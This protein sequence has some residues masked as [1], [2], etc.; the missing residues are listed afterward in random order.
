MITDFN[1]IIIGAGASGLLAACNLNGV[2]T[3]LIEKNTCAG[4]KMLISGAGQCNFTH[5]GELDDFLKKYGANS[6]FLKPALYNFNNNDSIK[7]FEKLGVESVIRDDGKVFP[8]SLK[9]ND[10]LSAL[11]QKIKKNK[12]L[13]K[14]NCC[15]AEVKY[16]SEL[17]FFTIKTGNEKFTSKNLIIS[18]GGK[19]YPITGSTGDG[20][21]IARSLGHSIVETSPCLTPI[22]VA[23]YKF[24]ELSG[25]SFKDIQVSLWRN[26]KKIKETKGDLLLTHKN[27][28]GPVILNFSKYVKVGDIIKINF[29]GL[30][31]DRI[32]ELIKKVTKQNGKQLVKSIFKDTN[33]S[34]RF[35]DKIFYINNIK[36]DTI[37][38]Q[39]SRKDKQ[40]LINSL[41]SYEF[42]VE[43]LG[44]YHIAMA[45]AGGVSL[46]EVNRK[47]MQSKLVKGLYFTGEV[48]DIDGETGGYNIQAAFSTAMLATKSI[49][50]NL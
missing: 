30:T 42:K 31:N 47:T 8:K 28:S 45:T 33:L 41:F 22:N 39:L 19:S 10:I 43:S 37:C 18:T 49:S 29:I 44:G 21:S 36:D 15:V 17:E 1:T 7:Y 2:K 38:S 46:D 34:K 6:S 4:K 35:I 13:V 5:S 50:N 3:L 23:E 12:A 32:N 20:Y 9:A 26:N 16:N 24:S 25:V 27:L 14:Y 40:S 48:L 11:L